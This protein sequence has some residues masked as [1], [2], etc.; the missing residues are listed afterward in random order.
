M[1][2]PLA[3]SSARI[4][5]C[6]QITPIGGLLD[7]PALLRLGHLT[8]LDAP[9]VAG[10]WALCF[11]SA[12]RIHLPGW[13]PLLLVLGTWS[14][15]VG[16]RLLDARRALASD[17]TRSLRERHYFHWRHRRLLIPLAASAAA[18]AATIIFSKMPAA[19][20]ERDSVLA[21][22]ALVYFSG[23]HLPG[24]QRRIPT[25]LVPA[26]SRLAPLR[27]KEFL[28]A[29]LFTAGCALPT[30]TR[31]HGVSTASLA[32]LLLLIAYFACLAW[33]NCAA[34]ECWE[35]GGASRIGARA[36]VLGGAGLLGGVAC[37][38]A[39]LPMGLALIAGAASALLLGVLDRRREKLTPVSLRC[40]ADL[41]L[42]TPIVCLFR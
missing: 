20:R 31:L 27:S 8:S 22:A 21:L 15:Y 6:A 9:A 24:A 40:A 16:D 26:P 12:A 1:P 35:S 25:L 39:N 13:V 17:Q 18:A 36:L 33:L 41:V 2:L 10:L 19:L 3:N 30:L 11:A 38:A 4:G 34:I 28:V 7:L 14:V 32:A 29:I 42:L 5:R 23:V 37:A